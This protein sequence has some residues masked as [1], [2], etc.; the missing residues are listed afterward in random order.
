MPTTRDD[1]YASQEM[2]QEESVE[3]EMRQVEAEVKR[4]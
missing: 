3:R 2:D 1:L 4:K